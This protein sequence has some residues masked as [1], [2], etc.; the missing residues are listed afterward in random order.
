VEE[1]IEFFRQLIDEYGLFA[2]L[3]AFAAFNYIMI[4][5]NQRKSEDA[6]EKA[7]SAQKDANTTQQNIISEQFK[8][9]SEENSQLRASI[10]KLE[11]EQRDA[12][13]ERTRMSVELATYSKVVEEQKREIA[14][15]HAK[16]TRLELEVKQLSDKVLTLES[17]RVTQENE[18]LR[19][20]TDAETLKISLRN[21]NEQIVLLR[22]RVTKLE[23]ENSTLRELFAKV[24]FI[25]VHSAGDI[26]KK[27]E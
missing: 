23:G 26:P 27:T 21:A 22:E 11:A 25:A 14:E 17:I 6:Q 5:R 13:N 8:K 7:E 19:E 4:L 20:R 15:A 16:S 3:A 2:A 10:D 12:Q 9:F 18:L 1:L 24:E